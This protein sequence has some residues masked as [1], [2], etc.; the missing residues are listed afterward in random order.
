[1]CSVHYSSAVYSSIK[2]APGLH[3][4]GREGPSFMSSWVEIFDVGNQEEGAGKTG[5]FKR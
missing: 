1:M 3:H 2:F 4:R 5:R